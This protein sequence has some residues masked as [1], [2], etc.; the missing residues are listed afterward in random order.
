MCYSDATPLRSRPDGR[1]RRPSNGL[2]RQAALSDSNGPVQHV[3][4]KELV[5]RHPDWQRRETEAWEQLNAGLVPMFQCA[6]MLNRSLVEISMLPALANMETIDPR[7]RMLVYNYSGAREVS[8]RL[9]QSI[10]IDPTALVTAGMLGLLDRMVSAVKKVVVPHSTLGWLFE[11]RQRIR[12]HQPTKIENAREIGHLLDSGVLKQVQPT[13]SIN[14]ELTAEVGE[15]LGKLFAEAEAEW[16]SDRRP[17]RVVRSAPIHRAGSLME[18]EADLGPHRTYVCGCLDVID[19]LVQRGRLTRAEE[20]RA[21][22]YLSLHERPWSGISVVG[23]GSVLYMDSLA[24]SYFQ[25]L[26]LLP[27]V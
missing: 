20:H 17:R 14:E 26:R 19:A 18:E 24:L 10:A 22:T 16:G 13:A 21:R 7:R 5:D 12:F 1:T 15:E 6:R 4:L 2:N 11:E 23:P 9:P 3:P 8:S 25:H 27:K